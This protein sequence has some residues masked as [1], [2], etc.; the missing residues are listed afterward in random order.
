MLSVVYAVVVCLSV[1]LSVTLRYCMKTAKRRIT[2]IMLHDS[3]GNLVSVVKNH[4]EIPTG[5]P[6][7]EAT[8]AGGVVIYTLSNGNVSDDLG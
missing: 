6:P 7:T 1:C 3:S 8:S 4:S 5:S 2:Q